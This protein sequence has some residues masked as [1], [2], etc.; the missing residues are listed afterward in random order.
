M[1]Q[2]TI[3]A[4]E[5]ESKLFDAIALKYGLTLNQV[6]GLYE[7]ASEMSQGIADRGLNV[8][9]FFTVREQVD[10]GKALK[11]LTER[12][13]D[14]EAALAY[15]SSTNENVTL[16]TTEDGK[17]WVEGINGC[18]RDDYLEMQDYMS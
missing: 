3:T 12:T 7:M 8:V 6:K 15:V 17:V 18:R 5:A 16:L 1:S 10:M 2:V 9:P 11:A 4:T 14:L 13:R